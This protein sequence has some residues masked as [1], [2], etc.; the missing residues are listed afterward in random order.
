M[1]SWNDSLCPQPRRNE[2]SEQSKFRLCCVVA[3]HP[4]RLAVMGRRIEEVEPRG[5]G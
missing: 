3:V 4:F 5:N 1:I 2:F